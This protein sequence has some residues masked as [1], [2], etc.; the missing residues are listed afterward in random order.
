MSAAPEREKP[1]PPQEAMLQIICGFWMSR[2]VYIIAKLGIPDLLKEGPRTAHELAAAT[3]THAP[4]LYRVLRALV[5]VGVLDSKEG[6]K[7][8]EKSI[9]ILRNCRK[10]MSAEGRL[11]IVDTV[12][13]ETTEPHFSKFFDLNMLVMT[14][15]KERTET[16]FRD[17]FE[18]AEFKLLRLIPTDLPTSVIEGQPA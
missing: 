13:P 14:G 5:S 7:F 16:E 1:L 3:A 4:S 12:V 2:V 8:D 18:A 10:H 11:I 6:G 9:R 15:G 17:L